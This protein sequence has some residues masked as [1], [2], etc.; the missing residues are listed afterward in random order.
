MS[1][2]SYSFYSLP[3]KLQDKG[4]HF[5]FPSLKLSNKEI[6]EYYKIIFLFISIHSIPPPKQGPSSLYFS[7]ISLPL[8]YSLF[9]PFL[10]LILS[11]YVKPLSLALL[12]PLGVGFI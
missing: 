11:H 5:P 8:S 12:D 1:V 4:M 10:S 9:C 2:S 3:L 6:E 7:L